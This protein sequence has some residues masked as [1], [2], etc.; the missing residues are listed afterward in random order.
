ML[1]DGRD[2]GDLYRSN[3]RVSGLYT[4]SGLWLDGHLSFSVESS[5]V[6]DREALFALVQIRAYEELNG[7]PVGGTATLGR[8]G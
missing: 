4:M 2:V 5:T 6:A 8:L 1:L 3:K 7:H